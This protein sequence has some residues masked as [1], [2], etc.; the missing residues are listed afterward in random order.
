MRNVYRD[1]RKRWKLKA[2]GQW[3]VALADCIPLAASNILG[4]PIRIFSSD[5]SNPTY[6]IKPDI[7][8]HTDDYIYLA[9]VKIRNKEHFDGATHLKIP[10]RTEDQ[11]SS[12]TIAQTPSKQNEQHG[13]G[14]QHSSETI[15]QTPSKQNE[16]HRSMNDITPH[17]KAV[18]VTP[19]KENL[20]RKRNVVLWKRK[21][22]S[23][24]EGR[25]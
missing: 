11:Y 5:M 24:T 6:D 1:T 10:E 15:T 12:E 25:D 9:Y 2:K 19:K 16:Q 23:A 18:F 4:R 7:N 21:K 13:T 3:N 14:D 22:E 8:E 20:S 17:K